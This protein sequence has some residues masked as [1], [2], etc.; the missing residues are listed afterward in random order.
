MKFVFVLAVGS[1]YNPQSYKGQIPHDAVAKNSPYRLLP[2]KQGTGIV[3]EDDVGYVYYKDNVNRDGTSSWLCKNRRKHK[4]G[5][6]VKVVGDAIVWQRRE[7]NHE[8]D[9]KVVMWELKQ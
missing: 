9:Q 6:V 8:I 2:A 1:Y 4:C 7:H 5:V 3:L